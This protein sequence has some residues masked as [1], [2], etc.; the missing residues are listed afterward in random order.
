MNQEITKTQPILDTVLDRTTL[1]QVV[2]SGDTS[3]MNVEQKL[4]YYQVMCEASGLDPRTVPFQFIK[5]DGGERLYATKG[6]TNQLGL[7]HKVSCTLTKQEI[8]MGIIVTSVVATTPD[9]RSTPEI[10]AVA[11]DG[12]Q[13]KQLANAMMTSLTKAKRR[14]VLSHCGLGV[15]DET[16]TDTMVG[17]QATYVPQLPNTPAPVAQP[18]LQAAPPQPATEQPAEVESPKRGRPRKETAVASESAPDPLTPPATVYDPFPKPASAPA[19]QPAPAAQPAP[20]AP[21]QQTLTPEPV[22]PTP[23]PAAAP[24]AQPQGKPKGRGARMGDVL[25]KAGT[26][27]NNGAAF[28]QRVVGSKIQDA[29]PIML[30][31][32]VRAIEAFSASEEKR[33]VQAFINNETPNWVDEKSWRAI[34]DKFTQIFMREVQKLQEQTGAK[35]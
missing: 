11:I 26:S 16:E 13:G 5:T 28:L 17:A 4:Q 18:A 2:T 9:G 14:A 6:A 35:A 32:A 1:F 25:S 19:P 29:N 3:A 22:Q 33:V 21:V 31:A 12:M 30:E 8:L 15:L 34:C 24:S 7:K 27:V 23:P 10:G 20:V